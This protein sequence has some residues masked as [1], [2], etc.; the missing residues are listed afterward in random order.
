MYKSHV[1]AHFGSQV[2]V[3][4]AIGITKSAVSQWPELI[5]ESK[6]YR[7]Q[8]FTGGVLKVDPSLYRRDVPAVA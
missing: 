7:I 1:L 6:A 4:Q 5:P 8:E 3:A 2:A